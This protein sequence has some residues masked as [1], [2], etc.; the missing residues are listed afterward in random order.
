MEGYLKKTG[1]F[2]VSKKRWC[3][4]DDATGCFLTAPNQGGKLKVNNDVSQ[5]TCDLIEWRGRTYLRIVDGQKVRH[6]TSDSVP[7]LSRWRDAFARLQARRAAPSRV[8]DG[9]S[10]LLTASKRLQNALFG[11]VSVPSRGLRPGAATRPPSPHPRSSPRQSAPQAGAAGKSDG[12]ASHPGP[13][14]LVASGEADAGNGDTAA[15]G[16]AAS[17]SDAHAYPG[18]APDSATS[19]TGTDEEDSASSLCTDFTFAS[20]AT[21]CSSGSEAGGESAGEGEAS[22][23]AAAESGARQAARGTVRTPLA[24]VGGSTTT[25]AARR[26]QAGP[27]RPGRPH[28]AAAPERGRSQG[29][30]PA[31]DSTGTAQ[32]AA[33][34]PLPY[35]T[36]P[37]IQRFSR[38]RVYETETV[39]VGVWACVWKGE[40]AGAGAAV[41][42]CGADS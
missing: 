31:A 9:E 12:D 32:A 2:G 24:R 17:F 22:A 28:G 27:A 42:G 7:E 23:G 26:A 8:D 5:C 37:Y 30:V 29:A 36:P 20:P 4:L 41:S 1:K 25:A 10:H 16:H 39:R 11:K 19:D 13:T 33:L 35:Y 18:I 15:L 3:L 40:R 21:L 6:Y 14:S 38:I 34:A